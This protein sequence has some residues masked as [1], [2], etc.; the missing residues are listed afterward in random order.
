MARLEEAG[1]A[2]ATVRIA[3]RIGFLGQFSPIVKALMGGGLAW[4]TRNR[5]GT[6]MNVAYGAGIGLAIDGIADL[7]LGGRR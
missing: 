6:L 1:T 4:V 5:S 3:P 7:A 2:A